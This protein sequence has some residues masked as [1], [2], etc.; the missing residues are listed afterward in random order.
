MKNHGDLRTFLNNTSVKEAAYNRQYHEPLPSELKGRPLREV[1]QYMNRWR[2]TIWL[3]HQTRNIPGFGQCPQC[4]RK[5]PMDRH[6]C[7]RFPTDKVIYKDG[8]PTQQHKYLAQDGA[9]VS[10]GTVAVVDL[11]K[12]NEAYTKM[13]KAGFTPPELSQPT[14]KS[15]PTPASTTPALKTESPL[16][17]QTGLPTPS[18]TL[19]DTKNTGPG[20][21]PTP[22]TIPSNPQPTNQGFSLAQTQH[23]TSDTYGQTSPAFPD[24]RPVASDIPT[25]YGQGLQVPPAHQ[26]STSYPTIQPSRPSRWDQVPTTTQHQTQQPD[27]ANQFNNRDFRGGQWPTLTPQQQKEYLENLSQQYDSHTQHPSPH[28]TYPAQ[29]VHSAPNPT[30]PAQP[31]SNPE[32][33]TTQ[34]ESPDQSDLL[35]RDVQMQGAPSCLAE[36][37]FHAPSFLAEVH[38]PS[39]SPATRIPV[40]K[41]QRKAHDPTRKVETSKLLLPPLAGKL[42][43]SSVS[44]YSSDRS[45][46]ASPASLSVSQDFHQRGQE[47]APNLQ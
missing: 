3:E 19:F 4:L 24:P 28:Q 30:T 2:E 16:P 21:L 37:R 1:I 25:S 11:D 38:R 10:T 15:T 43:R 23:P 31:V 45:S 27:H 42:T 12:M 13:V 40:T 39:P 14:A 29:P 47:P 22:N 17:I 44:S 9:K 8:V 5:V 6:V 7:H 26:A 32:A 41:I 35:F 18:T 20:V 46:P 33:Q 34:A 36:A